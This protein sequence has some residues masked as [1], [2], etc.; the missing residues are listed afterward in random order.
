VRRVLLG[1]LRHDVKRPLHHAARGQEPVC[2]DPQLVRV[3]AQYHHL[4][5]IVVVEVD[6]Q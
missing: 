6:M 4:Q 2:L 3:S 1:I 5:A